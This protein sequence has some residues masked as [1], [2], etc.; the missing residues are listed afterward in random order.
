MTQ[1]RLAR[2]DRSPARRSGTET[3]DEWQ[4]SR[5]GVLA[6]LVV[7][8][9]LLAAACGGGGGSPGKSRPKVHQELVAF[10]HCMRAHGVPDLPDPLPDGGFPRTGTGN[11]GLSPVR[12]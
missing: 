10:A 12:R 1:A 8:V 9:A 3:D 4:H 2:P 11:S 7:G 5:A 6:A